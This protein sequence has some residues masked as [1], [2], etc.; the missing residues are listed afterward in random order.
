M[1]IGSAEP[2]TY[3][4][5]NTA[6]HHPAG[7]DTA[8]I[9]TITAVAGH[10][11]VIDQITYSYE[12]GAPTAGGLTVSFA[13]VAKYKQYITAEQTK[14]IAPPGGIYN[15]T[16]TPNEEVV[17]KLNDAGAGVSGK[18]NA[19]YRT[20]PEQPEILARGTFTSKATASGSA[21]TETFAA[22][23]GVI[24]ALDF[25]HVSYAV[26]PT[27]GNLDVA[28]GG[29]TVWQVDIVAA[30]DHYFDFHKPL[31]GAAGAAMVVTLADG[32]QAK[33]LNCKYR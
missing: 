12:G 1:R 33:Y 2:E 29:S 7:D 11:H 23:T 32:S 30:G 17:I 26:A 10:I 18:L 5:I 24:H 15:Q 14:E 3:A 9:I 8:A 25:V 20:I 21:S 13:G 6:K 31:Y 16:Q 28:I 27:A 22:A 19:M 4:V